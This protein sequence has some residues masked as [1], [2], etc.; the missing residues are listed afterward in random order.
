MKTKFF[1]PWLILVSR[2]ICFFIFQIL[3]MAVLHAGG[4]LNAWNESVRWW[5]F[6]P[7]F[8]NAISIFLLIRLY[9]AE[10]L[11]YRDVISFSRS[12]L[13]SD[14]IWFLGSLII[15]LPI[16]VAPMNTLAAKIFGDAMEP[17]H[18]MFLPLP[19][20]AL[21]VSLLFP[22]TIGFAELP[23]YFAYAMPRIGKQL[24]N[25]WAA[26]LIASFFLGAQHIFLPLIFDGRFI[27]WRLLMYMPFALFVGLLLKLRPSL[28]PFMMIIHTFADFSAL[29]VYLMI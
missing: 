19:G 10:G 28:L 14:L 23:T 18:M 8:T 1:H 5:V 27:V 15:G 22:L 20:W 7:I 3:I 9:Q 6:L 17:I 24:K 13:K 21:V 11:R 25:D 16:M 4:S 2:S 12:T 26:W 29:A